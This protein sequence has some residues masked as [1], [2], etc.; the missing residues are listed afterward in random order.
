MRQVF[1]SVRRRRSKEEQFKN[2]FKF[3]ESSL[4][5]L[6]NEL[7]ADWTTQSQKSSPKN[8]RVWPLATT[9]QLKKSPGGV[10]PHA[11]TSRNRF[12]AFLTAA[13]R[14]FAKGWFLWFY[15]LGESQKW[16]LSIKSERKKKCTLCSIIFKNPTKIQ[17]KFIGVMK[18]IG[19]IRI[20]MTKKCTQFHAG[21]TSL[22]L[23]SLCVIQSSLTR[24]FLSATFGVEN[25]LPKNCT[26]IDSFQTGLYDKM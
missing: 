20:F 9:K 1:W 2:Y 18:L 21:I 7:E 5:R 4:R 10:K 25:P 3:S 8:L 13:H 11:R 16:S 24:S 22:R 14:F 23:S 26:K 12:Q 17:I 15:C 19:D 6:L